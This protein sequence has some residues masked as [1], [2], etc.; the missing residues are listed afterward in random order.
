MCLG[1]QA[2][3]QETTLIRLSALPALQEATRGPTIPPIHPQLLA[4]SPGA[5]LT[6]TIPTESKFAATS[7]PV[8]S[9]Q[10]LTP[11]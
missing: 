7:L 6:A 10:P 9:P 4:V 1:L 11:I 2:E 8:A 5:P 3:A